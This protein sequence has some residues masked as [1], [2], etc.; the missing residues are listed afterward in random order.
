MFLAALMSSL[1][2]SNAPAQVAVIPFQRTQDLSPDD[3]L[4]L[5][6]VIQGLVDESPR[7]QLV[8]VSLEDLMA[9]RVPQFVL[10]GS[11]RRSNSGSYELE[12]NLQVKGQTQPISATV[13]QGADL[14][15]LAGSV[16]DV[17]ASLFGEPKAQPQ[18]AGPTKQPPSTMEAPSTSA[19][20][21]G[22]FSRPWQ[23]FAALGGGA[24]ALVGG[25]INYLARSQILDLESEYETARNSDPAEA[26]R[27]R[28]AQNSAV[29]RFK[30]VDQPVSLGMV[31]LG[32]AL[33]IAGLIP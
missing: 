30:T 20:N 32:L 28:E 16:E 26:E 18:I 23:K 21:S 19:R 15:A 5:Q 8:Q 25:G 31:G 7:F 24:M 12:L 17:L 11:L 10:A 4:L 27:V 29:E 1:L 3:S 9:G 14:P 22:V 6:E 13:R 2:A 33:V